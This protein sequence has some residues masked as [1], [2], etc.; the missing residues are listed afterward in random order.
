MWID[1][2]NTVFRLTALLTLVSQTIWF[3]YCR[4]VS[5]F[6]PIPTQPTCKCI[7]GSWLPTYL[8]TQ[9]I[10]GKKVS[11][12]N[13][14]IQKWMFPSFILVRSHFI[15]FV[16]PNLQSFQVRAGFCIIFSNKCLLAWAAHTP[17]QY[18]STAEEIPD[19]LQCFN[20]V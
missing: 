6:V 1:P 12:T 7:I 10:G 14:W 17:S 19:Y 16:P 2:E 13:T 20:I 9:K 11:W 8:H 3:N 5:V 15:N 18:F 4:Y